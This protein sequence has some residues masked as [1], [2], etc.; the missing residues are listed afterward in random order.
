MVESATEGGNDRSPSLIDDLVDIYE[1][2]IQNFLGREE[3]SIKE[4]IGHIRS[5]C[6][7]KNPSPYLIPLSCD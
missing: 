3:T 6:T 2:E 1:I 4:M 5:I 7:S